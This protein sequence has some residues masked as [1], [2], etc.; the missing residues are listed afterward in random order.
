MAMLNL[1][2]LLKSLWK[3]MMTISLIVH[4]VVTIASITSYLL[5]SLS[6]MHYEM[7]VM[8]CQ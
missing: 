3:D 8:A 5:P 1:L 2:L 7:L 4:P 6:T